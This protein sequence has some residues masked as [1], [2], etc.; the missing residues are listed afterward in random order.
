MLASPYFASACFGRCLGPQR[1][2]DIVKTTVAAIRRDQ[3]M[4]IASANAAEAG[5]V[6]PFLPA[7]G[8]ESQSSL[9]AEQEPRSHLPRELH[10]HLQ[11]LEHKAVKCDLARQMCRIVDGLLTLH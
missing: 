5:S 4:H 10:H 9:I 6:Q 2:A 11:R 7:A 8:E 1:H 3:H